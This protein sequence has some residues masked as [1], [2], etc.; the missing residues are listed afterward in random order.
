VKKE[1]RNL[2]LPSLVESIHT[3]K[4]KKSLKSVSDSTYSKEDQAKTKPGEAEIVQPTLKGVMNHDTDFPLPSLEA[5]VAAAQ[6]PLSRMIIFER[7][8]N[9]AMKTRK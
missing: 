5:A 6:I 8:L 1:E 7:S 2:D 4:L 9:G 3:S